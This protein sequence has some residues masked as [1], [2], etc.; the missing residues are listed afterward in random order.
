MLKKGFKDYSF[1]R[2]FEKA[3]RPHLKNYEILKKAVMIEERMIAPL[4]AVMAATFA[5]MISVKKIQSILK[6]DAV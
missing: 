3:E 6:E 4:A 2:N 1:E 5:I